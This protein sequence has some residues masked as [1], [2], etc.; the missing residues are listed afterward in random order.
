MQDLL[1]SQLTTLGLRAGDIVLAHASFK[2]LGV[3]DPEEVIGALL[4][5]LGPRG[6]LLMPALTYCQEPPQIH[7]TRSAP[8]CVGF[9]TEYFR[10]RTGTRRSLHP[11]HSVC[12]VGAHA[13][14]MLEQH[15]HDATPCGRNSPFNHLIQNAGKILMIGC[16]LRP[17]TTMHAIE[18]V[19]CPPYLFGPERD[20]LLTDRDGRVVLKTYVTHG[21][22][23]YR[24]RYDRAAALLSETELH[25]GPVGNAVCNL[26]E[27][28]ALHRRAVRAMQEAPFYFVEQVPE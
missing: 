17:N 12:A 24:Q 15:F 25:T 1:T 21:F 4:A 27:A 7:D 26:I 6:T 13:R 20:Y 14:T 28:S 18:E 3:R 9:L 23:G 19:V 16:G 11:T 2:S 5:A 22:T 8:S 10:T